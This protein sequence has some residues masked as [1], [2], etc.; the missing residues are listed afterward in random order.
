MSQVRVDKGFESRVNAWAAAQVPPIPVA[1]PNVAFTPPAG[2]YVRAFVLP[3]RTDSRDLQGLHRGYVGVFQITLYLPLNDGPRRASALVDS[4][5]AAFPLS[6]PIVVD[7]L[8]L[9]VTSPM[10]AAGPLDSPDRYVVPVSCRYAA[11]TI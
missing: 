9:H 8:R 10:S 2:R 3:G 5:D 1:W 6:D 7:G 11:N 4:L